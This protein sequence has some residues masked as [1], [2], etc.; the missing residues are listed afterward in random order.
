MS[1]AA[2]AAATTKAATEGRVARPVEDGFNEFFSFDF[3]GLG[4]DTTTTAAF[5]FEV[6]DVHLLGEGG[7]EGG[8][9]GVRG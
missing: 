4:A 9:E 6:G 7:R 1:A 2:A 3:G 8:K 5:F